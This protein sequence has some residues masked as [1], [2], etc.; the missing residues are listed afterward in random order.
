[1]P[2]GV[3]FASVETAVGSKSTKVVLIR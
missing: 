2:S 1:L 3:Y